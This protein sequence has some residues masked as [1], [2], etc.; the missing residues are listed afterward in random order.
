MRTYKL[1]LFNHAR[2]KS[3]L[4]K[5]ED[6]LAMDDKGAIANALDRFDTLLRAQ[7]PDKPKLERFKLLSD[8]LAT[9]AEVTAKERLR[10]LKGRR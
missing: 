2:P 8:G 1:Q 6:I 9:I 10:Q 7:R 3:R 4:A 5:V